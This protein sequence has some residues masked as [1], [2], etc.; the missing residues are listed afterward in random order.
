MTFSPFIIL[1]IPLWVYVARF[2]TSVIQ[3]EEVSLDYYL[4]FSKHKRT[5]TMQGISARIFGYSTLIGG[6][7]ISLGIISTLFS[8]SASYLAG[9]LFITLCPLGIL[10]NVLGVILGFSLQND[11]T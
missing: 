2:G 8:E 1:L 4:G 10:V 3:K 7:L 9:I 5:K 11:N 6:I